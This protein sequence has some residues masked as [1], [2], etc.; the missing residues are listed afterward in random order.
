M[1][2]NVF[3]VPQIRKVPEILCYFPVN[4]ELEFFDFNKGMVAN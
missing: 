1:L 2:L 3:A 4:F